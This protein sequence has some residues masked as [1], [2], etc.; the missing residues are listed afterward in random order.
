MRVNPFRISTLMWRS[1]VVAGIVCCV[2]VALWFRLADPTGFYATR[3]SI[4]G[5][6]R[7]GLTEPEVIRLMGEAPAYRYEKAGAPAEYYVNGWE[8]HERPITGKV[9]IFMLG[10]PICYVWFDEEGR[11]EEV[12]VG[13]S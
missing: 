4:A 11:V 13:G 1:V 5:K 2:G 12:F 9:L 7:L 10:E 3:D 6:L 8:R